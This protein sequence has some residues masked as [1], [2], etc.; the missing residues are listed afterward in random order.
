MDPD[1]AAKL[2]LRR[3]EMKIPVFETMNENELNYVKMINAGQG[4]FYNN[5]SFNV[6]VLLWPGNNDRHYQDKSLPLCSRRSWHLADSLWV[7]PLTSYRL[8]PHKLAH[9]IQNNLLRPS[10]RRDRGRLI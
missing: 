8:L 6:S 2:Y 4:F 9:K 5:V 3:I 1:E 7:V 10:W